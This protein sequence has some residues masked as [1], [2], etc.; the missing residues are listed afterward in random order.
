MKLHLG[1]FDQILPGWINTD[2]TPHLWIA[3]AP[4]AARLACL[5]GLISRERLAQHERGIF[6]KLRRL[7]VRRRFPYPDDSVT[8]VYSSHMLEHIPRSAAAFCLKECHRVLKPGGVIRIAVP[9]L[10]QWIREYDPAQ[11]DIFVTRAF[12]PSERR[13]KNQHHYLY[14]EISLGR[15]LQE[16]GFAHARRVQPGQGDCPDAAIIDCRPE[17]L[18]MEASKPG[19]S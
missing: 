6:A 13:S 15:L 4:G 8:A 3:R 12:E 2:V 18:I 10:D 9:D 5:L 19:A 14:N 17:S 16:C 1:A 11:P 7:D